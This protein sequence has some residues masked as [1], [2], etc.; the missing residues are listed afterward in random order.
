MRCAARKASERH[1]G[2]WLGIGFDLGAQG[3][4]HYPMQMLRHH[5]RFRHH[6]G[7]LLAGI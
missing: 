4:H 3:G 1:L 6:G 2:G 5:F 7:Q